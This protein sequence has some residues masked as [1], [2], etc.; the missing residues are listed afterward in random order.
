MMGFFYAKKVKNHIFNSLKYSTQ[1][2]Y[3]YPLFDFRR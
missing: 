3:S 1:F 2:K